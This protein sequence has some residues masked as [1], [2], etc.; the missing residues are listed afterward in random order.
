MFKNQIRSADTWTA[1][2]MEEI[3][4]LGDNGNVAEIFDLEPEEKKEKRGAELYSVLTSLVAGEP[5]TVIKGIPRVDGWTA[6]QKLFWRYKP[7]TQARALMAMRRVMEIRKVKDIRE[8]T[9]A[10]ET[11]EASSRTLEAEYDIKLDERIKLALLTKMLP[12]D[13]QDFRF[14]QCD[15]KDN[16]ET[17]RHNVMALARQNHDGDTGADGDWAVGR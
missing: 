15:E 7:R 16:C 2:K 9:M 3:E 11:W 8:L 10:V 14:Q 4:K 13:L 5:L 1:E 6:W 12:S 17:T